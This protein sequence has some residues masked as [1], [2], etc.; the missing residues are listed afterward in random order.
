[1]KHEQCA[2]VIQLQT[3]M[4][5]MEIRMTNRD[6]RWHELSNNMQT[7][8][9]TMQDEIQ[10]SIKE[11]QKEMV[12]RFEKQEEKIESFDSKYMPISKMDTIKNIGEEV[13]QNTNFKNKTL[14]ALILIGAIGAGNLITLI[15]QWGKML[16]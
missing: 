14:G 15:I 16:R 13:K 12:R 10:T 11:L 1:M 7:A 8:M 4:D 9:L 2:E 3:K 6:N 5:S